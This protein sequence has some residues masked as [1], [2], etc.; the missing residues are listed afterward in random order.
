MEYVRQETRHVAGLANR[1]GDPSPVTAHGV[2]RAIQACAKFRWGADEIAGRTVAVQGCGN[3]GYNLARELHQA[4]ARLVVTDAHPERLSR[5]C[6]E[7]DAQSVRPD[8]IY[9]VEADIFAPCALGGIINDQTIPQLKV[10]IVAGAANNQLLETRHGRALEAHGML[11][12]PDYVANAG[13]IINGCI[14]LLGWDRSYTLNRV[15]EI[16]EKLLMVFETAKAEGIP[17]FEAA[18]RL[19]ERRL[20]A[21]RVAGE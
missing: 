11:Y 1:S 10:E 12:A 21:A 18:D 2:F 9:G 8:E 6:E 19:A 17:T 13:G 15:R 5:V 16:Y 20:Q 14:E 4:G 7:F 3:V